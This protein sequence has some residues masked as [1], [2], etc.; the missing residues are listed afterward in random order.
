MEVRVFV[1][2]MLEQDIEG[3]IINTAAMSGFQSNPYNGSYNV[4]KHGVV[5]LS[6]TLY[7]ELA[8]RGAKLKVSVLCPGPV[9]TSFMKGERN[10][11]HELH[12][13]PRTVQINNEALKWE[14]VLIHTVQ[15][16]VTPPF[17]AN[18]VFNAVRSDR[19]YILTHLAQHP[20]YKQVLQTR[21]NDILQERNPTSPK[22]IR[23]K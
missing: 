2:L 17:I 13:A 3:H 23:S 4:S 12:N 11:P 14:Q 9:K 22:S 5:T 1:P 18:E 20:K 15:S 10:R 16:G 7:H 21:L 8:Q 19:F 6:E